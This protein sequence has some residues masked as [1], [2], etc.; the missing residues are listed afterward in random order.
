M[1]EIMA[2]VFVVLLLIIPLYVRHPE[3]SYWQSLR[4]LALTL[5]PVIIIWA[6]AYAVTLSVAA[7]VLK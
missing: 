2:I 1:I 6:I 4:G 3:Q 5:V 7:V